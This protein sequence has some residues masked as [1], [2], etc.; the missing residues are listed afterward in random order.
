MALEETD[1]LDGMAYDE[2]GGTLTLLLTDAWGWE[3]EAWH[4]ELL[5][6]KLGA[7]ATF[8][9]SGQ[10]RRSLPAGASPSRVVFDIRFALPIT[11]SCARLLRSAA[12]QLNDRLGVT[13]EV[14]T[15]DA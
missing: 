13:F 2:A 1:R 8:V 15:G 3:D 9:A 6:E 11:E 5:Q 4:L 7:Y 12:D 10:W 14:S